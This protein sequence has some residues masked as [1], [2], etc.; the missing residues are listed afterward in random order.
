MKLSK[1]KSR[2]PHF[3]VSCLSAAALTLGVGPAFAA[4][5][6]ELDGNAT[7]SGTIPGDD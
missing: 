7:S 2:F 5:P 3:V 1:R 4:P 6:F